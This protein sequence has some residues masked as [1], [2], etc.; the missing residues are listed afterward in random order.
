MQ[1]RHP[2]T[3]SKRTSWILSAR[4]STLALRCPIAC[5]VRARG[6]LQG[7]WVFGASADDS[8][9][10]S[11]ELSLLIYACYSTT[12]AAGAPAA[13]GDPS[14]MSSP[15]HLSCRRCREAAPAKQNQRLRLGSRMSGTGK[16]ITVMSEMK[17]CSGGSRDRLPSSRPI[18]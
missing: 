6:L 1:H 12:V 15:G 10:A 4:P 2:F 11:Q 13:Q 17:R 5:Q 16:V 18:G 14:L 3:K 9:T 8:F 7:F